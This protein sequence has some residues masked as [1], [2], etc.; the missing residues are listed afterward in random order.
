MF[1]LESMTKVKILDVRTLARKDRKP[2]EQAG[3][4]LLVQAILPS[5]ILA[6]FDGHLSS[7]LYRK[8]KQ[9]TQG[10][11]E[12]LEG[13]ELT[14]I[15]AHVKR[16]P[17]VYEQTGCTVEIDR[18]MGGKRN[19][20]LEDCKVHRVSL[21]P[22]QGG[23]VKTQWTIDAPALSDEMR[24]KLTGL[25]ATETEMSMAGPEVAQDDLDDEQ[26]ASTKKRGR[27][28]HEAGDAFAATH[29]H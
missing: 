28:G 12:G 14:E 8:A 2:D 18:G 6:M 23:G 3:A 26:P 19:L 21:A 9:G 24:G 15:G 13:E 1:E 11:L 25:K 29:T 10:K 16:M 20:V 27:S 22:Q 7:M 5:S 4:Q 17:W